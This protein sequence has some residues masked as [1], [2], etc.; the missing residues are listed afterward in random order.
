MLAVQHLKVAYG[1]TEVLRDVSFDVPEGKI[2]AL[3][4]GNGSG[5]TTVLNALTGL[6]RPRAG[7]VRLKER[8]APESGPTRSFAPGSRRCR[9]D[10]MSGRP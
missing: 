5:K 4:G 6:V 3:L 1:P 10:G 8:N 2:V 9:R 7:S